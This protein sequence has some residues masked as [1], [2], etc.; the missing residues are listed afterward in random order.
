MNTLKQFKNSN[1]LLSP[2]LL[3]NNRGLTKNH[4]RQRKVL[5]I[6]FFVPK[7]HLAWYLLKGI[8]LDLGIKNEVRI[9]N[10]GRVKERNTTP[11]YLGN[12]FS[13]LV[14]ISNTRPPVTKT[15]GLTKLKSP[16]GQ[17][18]PN[19]SKGA[20]IRTIQAIHTPNGIK[21][22]IHT[23]YNQKA[24]IGRLFSSIEQLQAF[25]QSQ[26]LSL[27]LLGARI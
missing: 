7:I 8:K 15:G 5:N 21:A 6:A 18:M 27:D 19:T 12:M 16:G 1:R 10:S 14:T 13:R 24:T 25:I 17:S 4:Q 23:R 3:S 11:I 20:I 26:G 22:S 2:G 9:P